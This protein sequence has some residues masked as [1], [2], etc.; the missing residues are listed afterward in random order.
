ML[1]D[2]VL[3]MIES[4]LTA[5]VAFL[6]DVDMVE[7]TRP[8]SL[9]GYKLNHAKGALLVLHQNSEYGEERMQ[10]DVVMNRIMNV[11]VYALIRAG[12]TGKL[13]HEYIDFITDTVGGMVI[14]NRF[15]TGIITP[16]SDEFVFEE[17]G[18]WCYGVTLTV[19]VE[20]VKMIDQVING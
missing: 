14:N 2:D 11:T 3:I 7:V 19:P 9:E 6:N 1:T 18:I 10:G 15:S 4:K 16:R 12:K 13:P 20:Y 8:S 5:A 17:Q